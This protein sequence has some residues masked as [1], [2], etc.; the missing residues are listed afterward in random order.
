MKSATALKRSEQFL[1]A[2]LLGLT[3]SSALAQQAPCSLP[4]NV[5]VPDLSSLSKDLAEE[6]TASWRQETSAGTTMGYFLA[7]GLVTL[8]LW[9]VVR[10]LPTEAFAAREKKHP[11]PIRSV[12]VDAGPRRIVFVADNGNDA[13]AAARRMEAAVIID[14]LSKARA[15]DSFA[16]LTARGPRVAL[17][18]GSNRGIIEAAAEK[19][20]APTA[21]R[22]GGQAVLDALLEASTWLQPPQS[23]DSVLL[24]AIRIEG[25]HKASVSSLRKALAAG[26]IRLFSF[27][28]G[29]TFVDDLKASGN[30]EFSV[31]NGIP[32]L[33]ARTGGV[34]VVEKPDVYQHELAEELEQV[35]HSAEQMYSAIT[36]YYVVQPG[37]I[38]A[39]LT[40]GLSPGPEQRLPPAVLLY[41][42]NVPRC[43]N[44]PAA[45]PKASGTVR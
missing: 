14:I 26:R 40:I 41:P 2:A 42:R 37:S 11:V 3:C 5:V 16:L 4:V 44:P 33:S 36:E 7:G 20:N 22:S 8:P 27:Q 39:H 29:P 10:G 6:A 13:T 43:S 30:F 25:R 24:L 28:F 31:S 34:A 1:A 23:G 35:R 9:T 19:L 32:S 18:L 17:R 45:N 21:R 15:V 12:T 38:D